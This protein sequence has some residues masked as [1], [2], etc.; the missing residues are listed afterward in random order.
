MPPDPHCWWRSGGQGGLEL[1]DAR[2]DGGREVNARWRAAQILVLSGLDPCVDP[3]PP[4][5]RSVPQ[6]LS[7]LTGVVSRS[8]PSN[9]SSPLHRSPQ[10][11]APLGSPPARGSF[12]DR[13]ACRTGRS[14][15][16]RRR[17]TSR[18]RGAGRRTRT[19]RPTAR[20]RPL[21]PSLALSCSFFATGGPVPET[22]GGE[23]PTPAELDGGKTA[24]PPRGHPLGPPPPVLTSHGRHHAGPRS[25]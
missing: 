7:P 13:V 12:G 1:G 8:M 10:H 24:P 16:H 20:L 23:L 21:R 2:L 9:R 18:R 14:P 4:V 11:S 6:H 17:G 19:A 25:P 3:W 15:S 5:L 22:A